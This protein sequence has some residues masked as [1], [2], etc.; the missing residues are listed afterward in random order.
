MQKSIE[1]ILGDTEGVAYFFPVFRFEGTDEAAPA[2][3]IQAALHAG[4][5]PGTVA[6]DALMPLLRK[7]EAEGRLRGRLTVVPHAN[8]VGRAQYHFGQI[9]GRFHL[10]TRDN[11]NRHFPLLDRPEAALA[12]SAG[13]TVDQRLK[14]RLVALSMGHDIVLDLHCDDEGVDYLYVPSTLWPAM[15]DCAAAMGVA[16][17]ILW[18]GSSGASFDEASLHPYLL[19]PAGEARLDRRVVTTVEYRGLLDVDRKLASADAEGLYRL[20]VAR[21]VIEDPTLASPGPFA[22]RVA[23][24]DHIDVVTAPCAGAILFDVIPGDR[25]RRGDRLATIVQAAGED[26]GCTDVFAPQSGTI[27]TR[28]C[29]R[30]THAGEDLLKLVGDGPS[31]TARQGALED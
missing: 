24:I 5:L 11:F 20:L 10:G 13:G 7:A 3:Y 9:Q 15:A 21:G 4:E 27:L 31:A 14:Q 30:T 12:E 28:V 1:T 8:P 22:G 23:P 18:E 25:V 17:V 29:R 2:A 19:M 6:V 16:A 26:G